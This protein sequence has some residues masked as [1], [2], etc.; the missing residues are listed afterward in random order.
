MLA[1][2]ILYRPSENAL[3]NS[4]RQTG[5]VTVRLAPSFESSSQVSG[6][7]SYTRLLL[8]IGDATARKGANRCFFAV[9]RANLVRQ[10]GRVRQTRAIGDIIAG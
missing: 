4:P 2:L 9:D 6:W 1:L 7:R 8:M 3:R 10:L 5:R